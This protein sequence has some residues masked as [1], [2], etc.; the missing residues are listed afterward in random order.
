MEEREHTTDARVPAEVPLRTKK[1]ALVLVTGG[2][3]SIP[4][5]LPKS[6]LSPSPKR[7]RRRRNQP[8]VKLLKPLLPRRKMKQRRKKRK[9]LDTKNTSRPKKTSVLKLL[10]LLQESP[11]KE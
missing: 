8:K 11:V 3:N 1:E 6:K 7:I 9:E 10:F 2:P 4:L 5:L